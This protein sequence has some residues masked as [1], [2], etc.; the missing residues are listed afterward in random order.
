MPTNTCALCRLILE[1]TNNTGICPHH[2]VYEGNW[3]IN[4]R[5]M[6]DGIHRGKW[7]KRLPKEERDA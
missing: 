7:P 2:I 6:C 3:A 4:N 5:I 1:A